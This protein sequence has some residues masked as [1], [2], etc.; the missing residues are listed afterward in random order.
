MDEAITQVWLIEKDPL[1]NSYTTLQILTKC[2]EIKS[3]VP[4]PTKRYN[5]NN[6]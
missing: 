4:F 1:I 5:L 6:S 3:K 2:G